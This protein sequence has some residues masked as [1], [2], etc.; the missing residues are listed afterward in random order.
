MGEW[1]PVWLMLL[2]RRFECSSSK[3]AALEAG[4][5]E[6]VAV[7]GCSFSGQGPLGSETHPEPRWT[8]HG[9]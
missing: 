5:E 7:V 6:Q 3:A 1:K 2:E 9:W 4:R 8:G